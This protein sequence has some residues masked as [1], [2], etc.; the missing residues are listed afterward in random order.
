M[1]QGSLTSTRMWLALSENIKA[2]Y[3]RDPLLGLEGGWLRGGT[4][5]LGI[6]D[7]SPRARMQ[8]ALGW[9]LRVG[10]NKVVAGGGSG[11]CQGL[12]ITGPLAQPGVWLGLG[13]DISA[14]CNRPFT[15]G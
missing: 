15:Q 1:V 12:G 13:W 4:L 9:I 7:P 14:G 3:N 2:R 8:L 6:T 10:Y 11:G 5:G